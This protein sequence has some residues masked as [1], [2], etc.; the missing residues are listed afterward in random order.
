[1]T[2]VDLCDSLT[3]SWYAQRSSRYCVEE[4][5]K[6]QYYEQF[7]Q[8]N[9]T[10]THCMGDCWMSYLGHV[11]HSDDSSNRE[12]QKTCPTGA[13]TTGRTCTKPCEKYVY[14]YNSSYIPKDEY[15]N[16]SGTR[17]DVR[18]T[19]CLD[20]C[21]DWAPILENNYMCAYS[22][23]DKE[24]FVDNGRCSS[25]CASGVFH[26]SGW[27]GSKICSNYVCPLYEVRYDD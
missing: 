7:V 4:C 17:I 26:Y 3:F 23:A 6:N 12:C 14:L 24:S 18:T 27:N 25:T 11:F 8:Y 5:E 16:S 2:C 20:Y 15:P 1:M 13:A 19:L 9:E 22:C 10:L 21:P